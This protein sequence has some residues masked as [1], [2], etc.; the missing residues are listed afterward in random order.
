MTTGRAQSKKA[1][2]SEPGSRLSPDL[3]S[4]GILI[5]D[6]STSRTMK[7]VS[8]DEACHNISMEKRKKIIG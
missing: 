7:V 5:L 8:I 2:V 1:A 3:K 4:I 6:F